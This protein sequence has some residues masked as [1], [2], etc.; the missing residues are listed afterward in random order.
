MTES[1]RLELL[2]RFFFFLSFFFFFYINSFLKIVDRVRRTVERALG[3][4]LAFL[5][6]LH[7][8]KGLEAQTHTLPAWK[9]HGRTDGRTAGSRR[10]LDDSCTSREWNIP[11]SC[12][13]FCF[14]VFFHFCRGGCVRVWRTNQ[15]FVLLRE[16]RIICMVCLYAVGAA[17]RPSKR[18]TAR[19]VFVS[20]TA[21]LWGISHQP[22]HTLTAAGFRND[23]F[24]RYKYKYIYINIYIQN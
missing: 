24:Y 1:P 5:K 12:S 22:T 10:V 19:P 9:T 2:C 23:K 14:Y 21:A 4:E 3:R 16:A 13:S 11:H 8:E 15:S 17:Q 7:P 20:Q 6:H 18:K